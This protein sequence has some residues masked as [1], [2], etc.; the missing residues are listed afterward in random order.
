MEITG[1]YVADDKHGEWGI[2]DSRGMRVAMGLDYDTAER[3]AHELNNP[4]IGD[5]NRKRL[6]ELT[7]ARSK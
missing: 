2:Y 3:K 1:Y 5:W 7:R 4:N 6:N